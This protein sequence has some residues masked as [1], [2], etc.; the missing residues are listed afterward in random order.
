MYLRFSAFYSDRMLI[1]HLPFN[2][3]I[4]AVSKLKAFADDKL[5]V[6]DIIFSAFDWLEIM[7]WEK[8]KNVLTNILGFFPTMFLIISSSSSVTVGIVR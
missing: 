3:K 6:A 7:Y 1:L 8:K 5:N 2:S 4:F